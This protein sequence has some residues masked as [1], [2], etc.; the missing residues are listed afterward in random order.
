MTHQLDHVEEIQRLNKTKAV[1][2]EILKNN[3][4]DTFAL[5]R[6]GCVFAKLGETDNAIYQFLKCIETEKTFT[7]PYRDLITLYQELGDIFTATFYIEKAIEI[8]PESKILI[9]KKAQLLYLIGNYEESISTFRKAIELDKDDYSSYEILISH[10]YELKKYDDAID[11]F[12]YA[13]KN[14]SQYFSEIILAKTNFL[15]KI[16]G[17]DG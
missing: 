4:K 11:V 1:L 14:L 2:E 8:N 17:N 7:F 15:L 10:L 12:D 13:I 5:W 9:L 6:L 3:P 16:K